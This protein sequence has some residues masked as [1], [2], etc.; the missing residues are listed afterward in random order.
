MRCYQLGGKGF[1]I[2]GQCHKPGKMVDT[3]SLEEGKCYFTPGKYVSLYL[4]RGDMMRFLPFNI[5]V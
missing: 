4:S 3:G 2:N 5:V 1:F